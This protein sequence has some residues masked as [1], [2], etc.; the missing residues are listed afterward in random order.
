MAEARNHA[1]SWS[2]EA[3]SAPGSS[4]RHRLGS[5]HPEGASPEDVVELQIPG[6]R[7]WSRPAQLWDGINGNDFMPSMYLSLENGQVDHTSPPLPDWSDSSCEHG[8]SDSSLQRAVEPFSEGAGSGRAT[9]PGSAMIHAEDL[10]SKFWNHCA[11]GKGKGALRQRPDAGRSPDPFAGG[12]SSS[13]QGRERYEGPMISADAHDIDFRNRSDA[14]S[15]ELAAACMLSLEQEFTAQA[16]ITMQF[17]DEAGRSNLAARERNYHMGKGQSSGSGRREED[18]GSG[19][20]GVQRPPWVSPDED[21]Q[22]ARGARLLSKGAR[23]AHPQYHGEVWPPES[24]GDAYRSASSR[25]PYR[26]DDFLSPHPVGL[27]S[28]TLSRF[29]GNPPGSYPYDDDMPSRGY[30]FGRVGDGDRR[31]SGFEGR[32]EQMKMQPWNA[33]AWQ[34]EGRSGAGGSAFGSSKGRTGQQETEQHRGGKKEQYGNQGKSRRKANSE[35]DSVVLRGLPFK[36]TDMTVLQFICHAGC[37]QFLAPTDKPI[38]ILNDVHGRPSGY[39]K[40]YVARS[41]HIE[42][43]KDRLHLRYFDNTR[44][45]EVLPHQRPCDTPNR[46]AD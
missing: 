30:N 32:S 19:D 23:A 13:S 8:W 26:S 41:S 43:L 46:S 35:A 34:A 40:I 21:F 15:S 11:V 7:F 38:K 20:S 31:Q 45:V 6:S 10:Q 3:A 17:W 22:R 39:C 5:C 14:I 12:H 16:G 24:E 29:Q 42:E 37:K 33:A 4:T 1:E 28:G 18:Y 27:L 44:Y 25:G 2:N 9:M 36:A